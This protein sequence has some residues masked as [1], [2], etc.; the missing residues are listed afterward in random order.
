MPI[1]FSKPPQACHNL[2]VRNAIPTLGP[3]TIATPPSILA[4][5][6]GLCT[7]TEPSDNGPRLNAIGMS[8]G[9]PCQ[10]LAAG[11]DINDESIIWE[12]GSPDTILFD[13]VHDPK[14]I[15]GTVG[16]Q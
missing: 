13:Y 16:V 12:P 14:Y 2:H 9:Y 1:I 7:A 15:Q 6:H 5:V 10:L 4:A 11:R 3:T 8:A